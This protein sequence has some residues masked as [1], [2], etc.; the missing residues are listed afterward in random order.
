M[1][2]SEWTPPR[3]KKAPEDEE[4]Q[5]EVEKDD[6]VSDNEGPEVEEATSG[7]NKRR[8][9][10]KDDESPFTPQQRYVWKKA[11][12]ATPGVPGNLTTD[13]MQPSRV[14]K[15]P[16]ERNAFKT[17]LFQGCAVLRHTQNKPTSVRILED[18]L[19]AME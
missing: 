19:Q 2:W 14:L 12:E 15:K 17:F 16:S 4:E 13:I 1:S 8:S 5:E 10:T 3:G 6:K 18:K 7:K 9:P 11:M